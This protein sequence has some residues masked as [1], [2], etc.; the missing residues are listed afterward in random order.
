VEKIDQGERAGER[1]CRQD[2]D[3]QV[4][5][6]GPAVDELT[7]CQLK[8]KIALT[9]RPHPQSP[10]QTHLKTDTSCTNPTEQQNDSNL[11]SHTPRTMRHLSQRL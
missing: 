4:K 11:Y 3:A 8:K 6:Y 9:P 1:P 10:S 2:R 7:H 5:V